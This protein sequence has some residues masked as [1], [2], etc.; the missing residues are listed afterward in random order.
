MGI[1]IISTGRYAPTKVVT[2][3]DLSKIVD[4]SDE[5]ISSR[6]GMKRRH[7]CEEESNTQMAYIA[8]SKALQ[9]ANISLDQIG[10]L[11]VSTFSADYY[12][13]ST[14]SLLQ[15]EL[16]IP[17]DVICFDLNAACSGFIFGLETARALLA[18]N[19][20]KYALLVGSEVISKKLD[21]TDRGTCILFGDGAGAVVLELDENRK[22][23][24]ICRSRGDENGISCSTA[25]TSDRK[26]KMDGQAIYKFAVSKVP[27][28]VKD[29]LVREELD[30]EQIDYYICH[31][32]NARII[33]SIARSLHQ[34]KA[35]FYR[36][37]HEYGNTSAA[38]IPIVLSEMDD[39]GLLKKGMK[40]LMAGFGAGL[41]WGGVLLEW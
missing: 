1:H 14:A 32:A 6:T 31:Q 5:W 33:D 4:T 11:I 35:K 22:Y 8:A 16:G 40:I 21:M 2:N 3:D 34:P 20:K 28:L 26:V 17:E 9:K 10:V 18:Q 23:S 24:S 41:T 39:E 19:D 13:P 15:K 12:V 30:A 38:S 25:E 29:L 7:F 37:I 27:D 36:N